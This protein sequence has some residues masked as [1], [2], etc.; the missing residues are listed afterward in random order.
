MT[1]KLY[2][3]GAQK[4]IDVGDPTGGDVPA[5]PSAKRR[6][7][8][9]AYTQVGL[10]EAAAAFKANRAQKAFVWLWLQYLAWRNHSATFALPNGELEQYGINRLVKCRALRDY[11]KAGL[12]EISQNGRQAMTVTLVA[13][14]YLI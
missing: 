5:K 4:W 3:R 13:R 10:K 2:S 12:I 11:E 14:V 8:K 7:M 1:K 6:R 9:T